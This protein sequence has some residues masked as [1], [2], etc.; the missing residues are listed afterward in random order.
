MMNVHEMSLM[1]EILLIIQKDAT[2]KDIKKLD[3]VE[4]MVGEVSNV[5]PDALYMAFEIYKEQNPHFINEN[6]TLIIQHEEAHAECIL[7]GKSYKPDQRIALCPD[8]KM[9]SGKITSGETFQVLTYE[10]K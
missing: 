1:G 2:A 5:L 10:G 9:P 4:L 3:R 7:C 8:C 6:A